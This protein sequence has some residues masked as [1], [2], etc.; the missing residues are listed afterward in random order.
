MH[1]H[2]PRLAHRWPWTVAQLAV[3]V[4]LLA[5]ASAAAQAPG[6]SVARHR[7]SLL[8]LVRE[9]IRG[10]EQEPADQVFKEI[11]L[12]RGA[13]ADRLLRV[14]DLGFSQSLGV[15]CDHCHDPADFSD[16]PRGKKAIARQMWAMARTISDT[17]L[18][19]IEGLESERPTVNCTTCHRGQIKPA[20]SLTPTGR[21]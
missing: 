17:L 15:A 18:M 4:F 21:Q 2:C 7:D 1:W 5:P 13:Q 10:R 19:R 8:G 3:M 6:D 14:M 16:D 9:R 20:T 12:F 11:R